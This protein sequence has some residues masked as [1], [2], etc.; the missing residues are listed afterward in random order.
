MGAIDTE[1][2]PSRKIAF[3]SAIRKVAVEDPE[4]GGLARLRW[5]GKNH[6]RSQSFGDDS[7]DRPTS[8]GGVCGAGADSF[9]V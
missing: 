1:N 4:T 6:V 2:Y 7:A 3:S 8:A 5:P 9:D